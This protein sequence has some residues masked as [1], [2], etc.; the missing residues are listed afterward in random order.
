MGNQ[1]IFKIVEN[2]DISKL[3]KL[4]K[5]N[6]SKINLNQKNEGIG[7]LHIATLFGNLQMVEELI[8]NEIDINLTG[9][10]GDTAL[11]LSCRLGKFSISQS[12][13]SSG[14]K[15]YIKNNGIAPIHDLCNRKK[16]SLHI[17]KNLIDNGAD[18]NCETRTGW[19]PIHC[20]SSNSSFKTVKYL[21]LRG[22][23]VNE[24]DYLGWTPL[25]YCS[26]IGDIQKA[27]ILLN[28]GAEINSCDIDLNTPLHIAISNN[29]SSGYIN[30]LLSQKADPNHQDKTGWTPMHKAIIRGNVK[31]LQELI[32]ANANCELAN[33]NGQTP[34]Q[35]A[36]ERGKKLIVKTLKDWT[37]KNKLNSE[38]IV[39][40]QGIIPSKIP[41]N[42]ILQHH[43]KNKL[44]KLKK[45]KRNIS[46]SNSHHFDSIKIKNH[47]IKEKILE[48]E[49]INYENENE[50]E[51]F[52][53][54]N[55]TKI[56]M[57]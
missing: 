8:S 9:P 13:I 34:L 52:S 24:K 37:E 2:G 17:L 1:N 6:K 50:I 10:A 43:V 49:K 51:I 26:Q 40:I 42:K 12:L 4:L 31:N 56:E 30:F 55:S 41:K 44:K 29:V 23:D 18:F 39:E 16:C 22:T 38:R 46:R 48:N 11:H 54:I 45:I 3:Q 25:H 14:A 27:K 5:S 53:S 47:P 36:L 28:E 57:N 20:A 15:T 35:I 19:K 33:F 32:Q 7:L 21:I